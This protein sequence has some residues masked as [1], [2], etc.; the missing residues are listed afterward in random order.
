MPRSRCPT[1]LLTCAVAFIPILGFAATN[2]E[3]VKSLAPTGI[4]RAAINYNNAVLA[5]R[6]AVTGKLSGIAVDLTKEIGRRTG[7]PVLLLPYESAGALGEDAASNKWDIAYLAVDPDR[8]KDIDFS[9]PYVLIEGSYMVAASSRFVTNEDLDADGI[10]IAVTSKS[11]YDLYLSRALHHAQ[12]VRS[13][14][15]PASIGMFLAQNLDAVAAVRS[16]LLDRANTTP[17]LR[18]IPGHFMT[19]PQAVGVPAG[20]LLA[21]TYLRRFIEEMKSSGFVAAAL[22]REGL[23]PNDALVAPPQAGSKGDL[24]H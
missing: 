6:D 1:F 8:A 11:A 12:L 16:I 2:G 5:R 9:P 17:G 20:R 10:R 14:N 23:G 21:A 3:L 18:V 13:E 22:K 24:Q 4:F 19:I 7:L 15:T